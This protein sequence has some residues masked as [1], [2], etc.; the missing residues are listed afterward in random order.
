M[1]AALA[2]PTRRS[3]AQFALRSGA[4]LTLGGAA[5]AA[6][7]YYVDPTFRRA[8]TF[9]SRVGPIAARYTFAQK[10]YAN[11]AVAQ[12]RAYEQLHDLYAPACVEVVLELRGLL[13]KFGQQLS[14][15]PELVPAQYVTAMRRLQ[16]DVPAEPTAAVISLVEAE[17]GAPIG[18]LFARFDVQPCG[19]ASIAQAHRAALLD[20][21]EVVV[22]VQF[23]HAAPHFAADLRGLRAL[24]WLAQPESMPLFDEFSRQYQTE[25]DFARERANLLEMRAAVQ[26]RYG[27]VVEVPELVPHR[28]SGRVLTMAFV[29]GEPLE[30]AVLAGLEA[31]GVNMGRTSLRAWLE[32]E[33]AAASAPAARQLAAMSS[34]ARELALR[35]VGVDALLWAYDLALRVRAR[36][37]DL[38][39]GLALAAAAVSLVGAAGAADAAAYSARARAAVTV[40]R[41]SL[42]MHNLFDVY[43]FELLETGF[44]NSDPHPGNVL[45]MPDGRLGLID[46]GQC[47]RLDAPMRAAL[48]GVIVAVAEG[49]SDAQV[50]SAF[51]KTGFRSVNDDERFIATVARLMLSRIDPAMLRG[52]ARRELFAGDKIQTFPPDLMSVWRAVALLRGSALSLRCNI[53]PAERWCAQARQQ[54][55]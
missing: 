42:L 46:Y 28:C 55:V 29:P 49:A 26:P 15:R 14:S 18:E 12:Q 11:D 20:G 40:G 13:V 4:T 43:G 50:A 54:L 47:K 51:R 6:A 48:A 27:H 53:S 3:W 17:L 10:W 36:A 31:A 34:S 25:L 33:P 5:A 19:A 39:A 24:V 7:G 35:L 8:V 32:T 22:K 23:A 2:R 52:K 37:A 45:V 41:A 30:R 16:S 44:F 9:W 38:F 1:S 21:R